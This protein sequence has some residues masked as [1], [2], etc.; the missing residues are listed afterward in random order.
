[1]SCLRVLGR[2]VAV[3]IIFLFI[4][5]TPPLILAHNVQNAILDSSY[6]DDALDDPPLF[7][8]ALHEAAQELP[9][10]LNNDP[11]TRGMPIA[12]L[13][14]TDWERALNAI[15]PPQD[16]QDWAQD[17]VDSFRKWLRSD[18][19]LFVDIVIPFGEIRDNIVEDREQTFLRLLVQVQPPCSEGQEPVSGPDGLIPECR[20]LGD[21]EEF[22]R[23]LGQIWR[24]R[25]REVW[26][27]LWPEA[28]ARFDDDVTLNDWIEDKTE[29]RWEQTTG[30][31]TTRWSLR[32]AD[33][34][35]VALLVGQAVISMG[36]V[37]LL[38]A[39]SWREA[40][41]WVG[42]PV[43]LAGVF[44]VLLTIAVLIAWDIGITFISED[45][46][47]RRGEALDQAVRSFS[48]TVWPP[49]I[50]QGGLLVL[51]GVGLWLVSL[52]FPAMEKR[53]PPPGAFPPSEPEA[54]GL[55][56]S[57]PPLVETSE[58]AT[59]PIELTEPAEPPPGEP[60]ALAELDQ[61][62]GPP[63]IGARD[64]PPLGLSAPVQPEPAPAAGPEPI[65]PDEP[66]Q[67]E[68]GPPA[69]AENT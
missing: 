61:P 4:V 20:P 39:R 31:R 12:R 9:D 1:M 44:T 22:S 43:V 10:I 27:Q 55:E 17:A 29:E 28:V 59:K 42:T 54:L 11:E 37:A 32:A 13:S 68:A 53:E 50:W 51:T 34:L 25:P 26:R 64:T 8:D 36:L 67:N 21:P 46:I 52:L 69:Q 2:A 65:P 23:G 35:L 14:A 15:V 6:L 18:E 5:V 30:W 24:D 57:V 49:M 45:S 38:A 47:L 62:V 60:K 7:E 58:P 41:R 19:R 48:N 66:A 33:W 16:L 56:P 63:G 40:F 3:F